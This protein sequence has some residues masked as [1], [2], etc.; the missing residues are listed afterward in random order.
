MLCLPRLFFCLAIEQGD[1]AWDEK[2]RVTMIKKRRDILSYTFVS[3]NTM[4]QLLFCV[5]IDTLEEVKTVPTNA[6]NLTPLFFDQ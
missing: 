2:E 6:T 3:L 1:M 4:P 5:S